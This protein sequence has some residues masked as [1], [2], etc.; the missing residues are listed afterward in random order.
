MTQTLEARV[1]A[2]FGRHMTVC[3]AS[4]RQL[5]ARPQG[6]SLVVVCGDQVR[7]RADPHHEEL[8]VIEVLPRSSA[9]YRANVRGGSEP[10]V[11]NLSHLLVVLA[12][13]PEPDL[14][15]VDRYLAA[16]SSAGVAATL[17]VNK[18]DLGIT[19]ELHAELAAYA[20]AGY[21]EVRC[22]ARSGAGLETLL[23]SLPRGAVAALVGQSGVGK[24]SLVLQLLPAER[25]AVGELVREE[26]GRHTTTTARLFELAEQRALIDSPG[27]RDFAPAIDRL[28][29]RSLGFPE[30]ARL[31]PECRF[32]DC[33]HMR[34][35]GCAVRGALEAGTLHPRR[36]ES[37]RRLWRLRDTLAA[38]R[39][40]R[41]RR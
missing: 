8:H 29:P 15:I 6:R 28:E 23:A 1:V 25:V 5:R 36:Y 37:Y 31:A 14:F 26:E 40:S 4:G 22:S 35:P 10:V 20:A 7:C 19:A 30:V 11:A 38:E 34:E 39:G 13:L 27:V 3:D 33:A 21:P 17:I 2:T 24:S 41:R 12:P 32:Q 9:L 16:A 18:Q